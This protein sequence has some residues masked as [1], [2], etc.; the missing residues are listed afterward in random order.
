MAPSPQM[1]ILLG[2]DQAKL[3]RASSILSTGLFVSMVTHSLYINIKNEEK[4]VLPVAYFVLSCT[5]SKLLPTSASWNYKPN[6]RGMR[7]ILH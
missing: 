1:E 3:P 7:L 6:R 4:L 5:R 2:A